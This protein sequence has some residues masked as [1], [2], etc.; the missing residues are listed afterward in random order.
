M[1]KR[2]WVLASAALAMTSLAAGTEAAD[3][4]GGT[5]YVA[6]DNWSG[7][8]FGANVGYVDASA[9]VSATIPRL[10]NVSVSRGGSDVTGGVI[11]GYNWQR[12]GNVYGL[13][14][15]INFPGN[16]DYLA[17]IRGR[18]GFL[19]DNWLLYGTAGVAFISSGERVIAGSI[20][21]DGYNSPGFVIGAGAETKITRRLSAGLEGLYYIFAE[22]SQDVL[23]GINVKTSVDVFSIRGRLTYQLDSAYDGLK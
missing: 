16:I 18:Y 2:T 11:A 9:D 12:G 17:S 3:I 21:Y 8:Y 4:K 14:A 10:G 5:P 19:N 1:S 13:E 7:F 15:D 20:R 6:V 22:D 23:P